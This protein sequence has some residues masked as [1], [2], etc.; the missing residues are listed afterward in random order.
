M[1]FVEIIKVEDNIATVVI[2]DL[3]LQKK[4]VI[5][6]GLE[7]EAGDTGIMVF[8]EGLTECAIVGIV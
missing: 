4:A 8:S 7:P 5:A 2:S 1:R 6:Q 3:G